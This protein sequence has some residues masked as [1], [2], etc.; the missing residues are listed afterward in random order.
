M[1]T[2]MLVVVAPLT[3][4]LL[5][6]A[7]WWGSSQLSKWIPEGRIKRILYKKL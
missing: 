7:A 6:G 1:H 2:V 4:L 3:N 5:F